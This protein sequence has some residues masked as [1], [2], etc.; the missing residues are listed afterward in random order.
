M[1]TR[2]KEETPVLPSTWLIATATLPFPVL[3]GGWLVGRGEPKLLGSELPYATGA[4]VPEP[5]FPS[6]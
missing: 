2:I 3:P 1:K 4:L 5:V 6:G